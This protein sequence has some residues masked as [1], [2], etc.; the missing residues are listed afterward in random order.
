MSESTSPQSNTSGASRRDFL[1]NSSV[2]A[3]TATV[4][5]SVLRPPAV[6]AAEDNKLQV[7]LVG[8]GGR[9]TGAAENALSVNNGEIQLTAMVDVFPEKLNAS[10][11][12]LSAK[13]GDKVAVP[14]DKK[15]IGFDG[16]KQAMDS[17]KPGDVVILATP[18]AFR[19]VQFEYAIEKGLNVFMEKPV[20]ADGPSSRRMLELA[21]KASE[22]NIKAAVG[23]M[24]RHCD[25]RKALIDQIRNGAIGDITFMRAYRMAGPT[26]SAF[27]P[28]KPENMNELMY[29]I[30]RFHSFLWLSGGAYSDFLIHNIDECCWV[31]DA[32]PVEAIASGGRHYRGEDIDQNFDTYS[33][34]YTFPDGTKLFLNGRCMPGCYDEFASYA[35][36]T[37]GVATISA[38]AHTPARCK[39]YKGHERVRKNEIWKAAESE[40]N[41]YQLEWDHLIAAIRED[42]PYNEIERGVIASVVTS[43]G[44]MAAHTGQKVT[45]DEM[46]N[47]K[48]E[49]APGG[50]AN[51]TLNGQSPLPAN[52][53]GTYPIPMPGILKNYEYDP[54]TGA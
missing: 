52:A 9:G 6:H 18:L 11:S 33:V 46:L 53:D 3:A 7:A 25:A 4:A 22:K 24:C 29:Q 41:P 28:K 37:K 39:I 21:K 23:L 12:G 51:L 2:A 8:C 48:H 50:V 30:S 47:H 19:G 13:F 54:R 44:R 20:T 40:P 5:T 10:H 45:Y 35:H 42:K 14:D 31:K 32:W 16:Y 34:E 15:F 27:S 26:A 43:M 17:L 36:G 38:S 49:F 1:R